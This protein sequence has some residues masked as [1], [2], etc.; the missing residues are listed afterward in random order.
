MQTFQAFSIEKAKERTGTVAHHRE[1]YTKNQKERV[2]IC[3]CLGNKS[4]APALQKN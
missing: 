4:E 3:R 2:Q 1:A